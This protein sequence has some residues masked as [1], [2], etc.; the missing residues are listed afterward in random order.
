MVKEAINDDVRRY[1]ACLDS[2]RHHLTIVSGTVSGR[3]NTGID[4]LHA[5]LILLHFRK[6]LEELA[7]S[8]LCA[9]VDKY[10]EAREKFAMFWQSKLLLQQIGQ[11]NPNFYP[12][13]MHFSGGVLVETSP[14]HITREDFTDLY[15]LSSNVLHSWNPYKNTPPPDIKYS[16]PEWLERF[17][18]L[19][20]VH[21]IQLVD[22][23]EVWIAMMPDAGSIQVG[24]SRLV[25]LPQSVP[26]VHG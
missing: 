13:P 2:I 25:P 26:E 3:I 4:E 12:V 9:N 24:V 22:H 5:E 10:S 1:Q 7:F 6:A 18:N 16:I 15:D 21:S 23:D 17:R 11:M 19:L 14:P 20:R 8:S